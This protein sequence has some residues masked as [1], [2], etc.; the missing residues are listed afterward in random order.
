[1]HG[2]LQYSF[3]FYLGGIAAVSQKVFSLAKLAFDGLCWM[4]HGIGTPIVEVYCDPSGFFDPEKQGGI[5]NFNVLRPDGS[6]VGFSE[7]QSKPV[8][9]NS[10]NVNNR[11][12]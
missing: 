9:V 4:K 6:F 7:V 12:T 1:M 8:N 11:L 10:V 3:P 5:V 2:T